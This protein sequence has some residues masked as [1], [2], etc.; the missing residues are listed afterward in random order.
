MLNRGQAGAQRSIS[1]RI[2]LERRPRCLGGCQRGGGTRC[3]N[4]SLTDQQR[5]VSPAAI[6]GVCGCP[7]ASVRLACTVQQ[8][9]SAPTSYIPTCSTSLRCT[10]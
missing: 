4:N 1:S 2:T 6:A 9:Y 10:R 8:L 7:L 5:S 3:H